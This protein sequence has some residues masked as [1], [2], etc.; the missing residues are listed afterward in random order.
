M[1]LAV[2]PHSMGVDVGTLETVFMRNMPPS[3]ANYAQR[4]DRAG[5]NNNTAAY[6]I[7]FCNK[8]SHD[9]TFFR[10]PE[11]MIKGKIKPPKFIVENDKIAIRHLYASSLGFF[12]QQYPEYFSKAAN[13][14]EVQ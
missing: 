14:A 2:L 6:A 10:Q 4:A 13:M 12:W 11:N 5:R 3:P 1:F 7:T 8:S 9:F